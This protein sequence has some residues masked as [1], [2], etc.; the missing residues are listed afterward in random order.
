MSL[1]CDFYLLNI[2]DFTNFHCSYD[3]LRTVRMDLDFSIGELA[4]VDIKSYFIVYMLTRA[5]NDEDLY[6]TGSFANIFYVQITQF[7][8]SNIKIRRRS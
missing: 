7:S 8:W 1:L 3:F 5:C 4:I 2:S 6:P